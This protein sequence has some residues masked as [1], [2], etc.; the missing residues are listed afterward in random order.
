MKIATSLMPVAWIA[1]AG[2]AAALGVTPAH[3]EL[4][5]S[6]VDPSMAHPAAWPVVHGGVPLRPDVERF[7]DELLARMTVE[8]KVGQMLQADI[9]SASPADVGIYAL[10][11]VLAGGN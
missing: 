11:S 3:A 8:E 9:S 5:V 2:V 7:V 4:P 1:I 6:A 10:G